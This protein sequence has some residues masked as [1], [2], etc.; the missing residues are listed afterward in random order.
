MAL[1]QL[2]RRAGG[3]IVGV[4]AIP[5][6]SR[7]VGEGEVERSDAG[8]NDPDHADFGEPSQTR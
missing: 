8:R 1:L 7:S 2:Y 3:G 5:L 6:I 4:P